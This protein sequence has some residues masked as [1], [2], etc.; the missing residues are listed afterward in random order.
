MIAEGFYKARA[1]VPL[2][3]GT[4][5]NKGTEELWTTFSILDDG[6]YKNAMIDWHGWLTENTEARVAESLRYCGYDGRDPASVMTNDVQLE[7]EHEVNTYTDTSGVQRTGRKAVVKWVNS[8]DR[9]RVTSKPM[10]PA[11]MMAAQERIR[12]LMLQQEAA[13][14]ATQGDSASFPHGANA[15]TPAATPNGPPPAAAAGTPKF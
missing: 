14:P 1:I 7:I 12:A 9:V 5:K 2:Q 13:R 4:A 10:E 8:V 11:R 6:P 3:G 15:S